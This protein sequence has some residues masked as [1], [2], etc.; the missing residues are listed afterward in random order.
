MT[1]VTRCLL[2]LSIASAVTVASCGRKADEAT[3]ITGGDVDRGKGAIQKYGCGACHTI[4]GVPGANATVGPSLQDIGKR[5]YIGGQPSS[6]DTM[7]QWIRHPKQID[8]KTPMP[9]M[10]VDEQDAKDIAAYLYT[11]R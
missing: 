5:A 3:R 9:E 10:N 1:R 7:M 6:V 4:P 8:P 11:L 2:M